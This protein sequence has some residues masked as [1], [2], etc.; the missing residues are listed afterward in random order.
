M[1]L[2]LFWKFRTA[3]NQEGYREAKYQPMWMQKEESS[4]VEQPPLRASSIEFNRQI[5]LV[6]RLQANKKK[7]HE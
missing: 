2:H 3:D 6:S 5:L 1:N 4:C 7:P